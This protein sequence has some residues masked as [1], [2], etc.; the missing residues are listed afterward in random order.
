MDI[1]PVFTPLRA[2]CTKRALRPVLGHAIVIAP[3]SSNRVGTHLHR[4]HRILCIEPIVG[5][6]HAG[7]FGLSEKAESHNQVSSYRVDHFTEKIKRGRTG[8]SDAKGKGHR[9]G[10]V[11][12][13]ACHGRVARHHLESASI[14]TSAVRACGASRLVALT[15]LRPP[16]YS[17]N[18]RSDRA[19][20]LLWLATRSFPPEVLEPVRR[21]RR[22]NRRRCNRSVPQPPL[23][24]PGV[25]PLLASA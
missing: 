14:R 5:Q 13:L 25:V 8:C 24:R 16:A 12:K 4:C 11:D 17:S 6:Y 21:Q 3:K 7:G 20:F 23:N 1:K 10:G 19:N 2:G 18:R 9:D 15:P 22:V